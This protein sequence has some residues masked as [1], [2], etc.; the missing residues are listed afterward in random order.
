LLSGGTEGS[1]RKQAAR[2][3][4]SHRFPAASTM[5]PFFIDLC[6]PIA[7]A[8]RK[9]TSGESGPDLLIKAV[10]PRKGFAEAGGA[11]V[12]DLTA[13]LGQ[14]SLLIATSGAKHVHM[15]ERDPV[16]AALLEDA[17][18]RVNLLAATTND[19]LALGVAGRLSF[20]QGDGREV[21]R[22]LFASADIDAFPDIVYLD[23]MFPARTKQASVKKNMQILHGLLGTQ[24]GD[25]SRPR[26]EEGDLLDL[27]YSIAR[28]RV[29]VK[30]PVH[31]EPIGGEAHSLKPS[32][33]VRGP[34]NRW[35]VYVKN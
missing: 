26:Q 11:I 23:P 21:A 3:K 14:D 8:L 29:V 28:V 34:V 13:G 5:K 22:D 6:P 4:L 16:V 35:D 17:L 12:Y 24:P 9:R 30:R 32:F 1:N 25:A 2:K 27:A 19:D 10:S 33:D 18:R 15:V 31:A 7:S 20:G